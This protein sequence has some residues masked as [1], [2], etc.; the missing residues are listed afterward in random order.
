MDETLVVTLRAVRTQAGS[1]TLGTPREARTTLTAVDTVIISVPD[2]EVNEAASPASA[3][4][5]VELDLRRT[6]TLSG[7]VKLRYETAHGSATSADYTASSGTRTIPAGSA[8]SYKHHYRRSV[9]C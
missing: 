8:S 1:V 5:V 9:Q 6:D 4:F 3:N 2:V 7:P